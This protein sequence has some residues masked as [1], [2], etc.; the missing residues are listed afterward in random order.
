MG[1]E[2]DLVLAPG[3]YW[4][5]ILEKKLQTILMSSKLHFDKRVM[6]HYLTALILSTSTRTRIQNFSLLRGLSPELPEV[7]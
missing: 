2:E 1:T 7:L 3:T 5:L 6:S 4:E